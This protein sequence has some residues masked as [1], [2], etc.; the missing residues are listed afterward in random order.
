VNILH[1]IV[2]HAG[3]AALLGIPVHAVSTTTFYSEWGP[4]NTL[5]QANIVNSSGPMMNLITGTLA[6]VGLR[7]SRVTRSS[8]K[9]FLWLF[10]TFSFILVT[11]NFVSAPLMQGGDFHEIII[12]VDNPN[13]WKPVIIGIG[14]IL[15]VVGYILPLRL[16]MPNLQG[17][18]SALI[19]ITVIPVFVAIIAQTL[20]LIGSPFAKLPPDQNHLLASV[21][22]FAHFLLWA[23][24]VNVLPV[25]RSRYPQ[26]Q[27]NLPRSDAVIVMGLVAA[28][29]FIGVLGPGLGPLEEDPRL[30]WFA[31]YLRLFKTLL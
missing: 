31:G 29:F 17:N 13:I 16:W 10:A 24:L 15:T 6:L 11:V 20:S 18:R 4:M 21:F 2:G 25:P 26:K 3:S 22:A 28:L 5:T 7:S 30:E 1:E 14:I 27:I 12:R 8:T 23:I 9:Y 19:V